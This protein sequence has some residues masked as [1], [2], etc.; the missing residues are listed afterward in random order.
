MK[1]NVF[2]KNTVE[3][4][5]NVIKEH[6]AAIKAM[7]EKAGEMPL[8]DVAQELLMEKFGISQIEAEEIVVD[9]KAGIENFDN[10]YKVTVEQER[11]SVVEQLA[12]KAK[13]LSDKERVDYYANILTAIQLLG[14]EDL[15]EDM[16]TA[17]QKENASK[18][19]EELATEIEAMLN[20]EISLDALADAVLNSVNKEALSKIAKEIEL[21]KDDYRFLVALWLYIDQREGKIKFSD[22]DVK[23]P[24]ATLGALAGASIEAL[25]ATND[26]NEG[27]IDLKRWQVI[28]KWILGTA[29]VVGIV[30]LTAY[31]AAFVGLS[32]ILLFMSLFGASLLSLIAATVLAIYVCGCWGE[33]IGDCSVK[34]LEYLSDVYDKYII[35]VTDKVAKWIAV[36]K[37]WVARTIQK[38]KQG[39]KSDSNSVEPNENIVDTQTNEGTTEET[40]VQPSLA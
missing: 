14:K 36:L 34:A 23:I 19:T 2:S 39:L 5:V 7:K 22:S 24:T 10:Q 35:I 26:L 32:A 12:E 20:G 6:E 16:V 4:A 11:I 18:T 33:A 37:K 17:K 27:K 28:M 13:D 8:A 38:A 9:L 3:Q 25:I 15:T 31:T 29:F 1:Q 40:F 21:R 30:F